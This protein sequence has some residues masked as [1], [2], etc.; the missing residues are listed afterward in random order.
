L[1]DIGAASFDRAAEA[2]P[3]GE[4]AARSLT[5]KLR[6]LSRPR[7][8]LRLSATRPTSQ[9]AE[10][11]TVDFIRIE[12][13]SRLSD[14]LISS[15]LRLRPGDRWDLDELEQDV[16]SIF[17]LD[18]FE[19]VDYQIV[20]EG[21]KTGIV[22]TATEKSA[23]LDSIRICLNLENDFD[24][25]SAYNVSV[26]YQ[27]EG[28]NELG[29]ELILQ[30]IA[31][32]QLGVTAAFVQPLDPATRYFITPR[33]AYLER[34]VSTFENGS[35]VAEFRVSTLIAGLTAAR[36]LGNWGA[37]SL[38]LDF[39]YGWKD[40]NV[41]SSSLQDD[42]FGIG[43]FFG[44]LNIDTLDNLHFPNSGTRE[45]VE[46]RHSTE[47]LG[48]EETFNNVTWQLLAA[49][50]WDRNTILIGGEV[51]ITFDGDAP[52][53][54]LFQLGGLFSLSGFEADELSGQNFAVGR[55]IAYRNIGAQ[56]GLLK[57]PIYL[58][59]SLEVGTVWEDR[60]DMGFDDLIVAGSGFTG[61]DTPL[62]PVY[63]AYGHAEGGNDSVYLF[64][65]QT[66]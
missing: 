58:G 41:G 25:D 33:I 39:G 65:G 36:Q 46:F 44:R 60:S 45:K 17:A 64:L 54:N 56:E 23:G 59:A 15:R 51:G 20:M 5:S 30:A 12:N 50:T 7:G 3:K 63:L 42:E 13:R 24:G 4:Q 32:E 61:V 6:K 9:E 11:I 47:A 55:L 29:G 2:I 43:E 40:L 66:F 52:T 1:G 26:R 27:K 10:P 21:D 35:R 22:I 31:G 14:D 19:T 8:T 28:V 62:A 57:F 37:I 16:A 18:Y 53:Q 49:R 48:G 34:D 38:G